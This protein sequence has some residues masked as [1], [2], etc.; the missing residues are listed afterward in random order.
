MTIVTESIGSIESK[1]GKWRARLIQS[2]VKG[3]SA[4]YSDESLKE[5]AHLFKAG[6]QMFANHLSTD[7][8]WSRPEGD[9]NNLVGVL[10]TDA[11]HEENDGLYA[12][13]K[14]FEHKKAWLKEVAPYVGLSIRASGI[15]EEAED[16]T[17]HLKSFTEVMSVDVVTKAGA[18]GKF[19]SL[20]ESAKP[21]VLTAVH[22]EITESK[23]DNMEF[24]KEL[25]EALDKNAKDQATVLEAVGKLVEALT[26]EPAPKAKEVE[27]EEARKLDV[28]ALIESGLGKASRARVTAAF[29]GGA[30]LAEAIKAEKDLAAEILAEAA[31]KEEGFSANLEESNGKEA[32]PVINWG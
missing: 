22:K 29:E 30:E 5:G 27:V 21:G 26:E 18:G 28:E 13:L 2:N 14:I 24:P 9:V 12:D 19:V 3:S 8:Q 1:N 4:Y 11:I 23:E 16:G 20:A 15:V 7:E 25:A 10:E 6:V 32:A 31:K 17:P